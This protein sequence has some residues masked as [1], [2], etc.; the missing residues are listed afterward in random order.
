MELKYKVWLEKDGKAVFGDGL[1]E[2]LEAVDREGSINRASAS[3]HMSYREAWGRIKEAEERLG[4]SLLHKHA[5]GEDGGGAELTDVARD[6]LAR[7]R[8]FRQD[9]D[10][11]MNRVFRSNF[12]SPTE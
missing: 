1:E 12:G 3:L 8:R 2:L 7:Y 10:E 6:L 4:T 5:G 9:V 11:A